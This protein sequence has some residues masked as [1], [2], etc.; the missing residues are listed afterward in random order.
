MLK[1]GI[2][3]VCSKSD[4]ASMNIR[5]RLLENF[6]FKPSGEDVHGEEVYRWGDVAIITF[7]RETIYLDEVEQ[8]VEASGVIFASRHAAESGMPAFLAHT[9]GNWTDE[10]L[11]GGRPR[12]VCIAM[13]LHLRSSILAL[14][15]LRIERGFSEW[16]C[17]LE[18]THHGPYLERTPAMFI[19]LGSTPNEWANSKAALV[20]AE[21]IVE[22]LKPQEGPVAVGFGGPHYAPQFTKILLRDGLAFSHII[23]KYAFPHVSKREIV[24]AVERSAVKPSLALIDW[25]SLKA[26]ERQLV[27]DACRELGLE[28]RKV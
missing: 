19:E 10:A 13:P 17:G 23:P 20:V 21:A 27:L 5:S 7:P 6:N 9:P 4:P 1:A 12:S 22:A 14:E 8:V 28:V 18:V 2:A 3:I 15:R 26:G 16:R 11:Y 25:K 24:Q